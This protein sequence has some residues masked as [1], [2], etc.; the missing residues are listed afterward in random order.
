MAKKILCFIGAPFYALALGSGMLI[1]SYFLI[2]WVMSFHWLGFFIWVLIAGWIVTGVTMWLIKIACKPLFRMTDTSKW[3]KWLPLLISIAF[4]FVIFYMPWGLD[5]LGS[6]LHYS[7][8]KI[9]LAIS[10]NIMDVYFSEAPILGLFKDWR[11]NV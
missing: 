8:R 10:L 6:D 9:L 5:F 3:A 2:P 4:L 11:D 7:V 1:V